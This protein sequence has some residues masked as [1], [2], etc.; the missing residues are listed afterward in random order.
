MQ[1]ITWWAVVQVGVVLFSFFIP[2]TFKESQVLTNTLMKEMLKM[3]ESISSIPRVKEI[4]K[5]FQKYLEKSFNIK[6][7]NLKDEK[8]LK[9]KLIY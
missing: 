6:N 4:H 2:Q 3:Q 5:N 1:D 8:T 9:T 7:E